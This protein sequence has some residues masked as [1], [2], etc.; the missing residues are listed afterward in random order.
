M[1]SNTRDRDIRDRQSDPQTNL[2]NRNLPNQAGTDSIN[3]MINQRTHTYCTQVLDTRDPV[4]QVKSTSRV[5][6]PYLL[7]NHKSTNTPLHKPNTRLETVSRH[8]PACSAAK[9][10]APQPAAPCAWPACDVGAVGIL[11]LEKLWRDHVQ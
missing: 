2:K 1:I 7:S 11:L 10:R 3:H 6:V 8:Y 9:V 4:Y 5:S